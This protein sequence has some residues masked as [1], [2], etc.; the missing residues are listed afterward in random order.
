MK[1][2]IKKNVL[3]LAILMALFYSCQ[4]ENIEE[5][6]TNENITEE[7][8][9]ENSGQLIAEIDFGDSGKIEFIQFSEDEILINSL[10]K[11][12]IELPVG[13]KL[14]PDEFY[15][16]VVTKHK[17][18]NSKNVVPLALKK[19]S[20]TL[21]ENEI[22]INKLEETDASELEILEPE[23][24]VNLFNKTTPAGVFY[25]TYCISPED[26]EAYPKSFCWSNVT[27]TCLVKRK[28]HW[29]D[30]YAVCFKGVISHQIKN[31]G[32]VITDY[33]VKSGFKSYV[34]STFGYDTFLGLFKIMP[35]KEVRVY[36][37]NYYDDGYHVFI[38]YY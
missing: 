1:H 10:V 21:R 8:F 19:L 12:E 7:T 16:K 22:I 31:N 23:P 29:M 6:I 25:T 15:K 36:N 2:L 32:K 17:N 35:T 37:A 38:K 27:G 26:G 5:N 9:T 11:N 28:T 30:S 13:E 14:Y 20:N 3:I 33:T 24:M 18:L 4:N 34:I